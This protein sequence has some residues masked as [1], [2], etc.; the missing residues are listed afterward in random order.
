M[1]EPTID[2]MLAWLDVNSRTEDWL[3]DCRDIAFLDSFL[4][5]LVDYI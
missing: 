4:V 3:R 2:E 5:I 1:T